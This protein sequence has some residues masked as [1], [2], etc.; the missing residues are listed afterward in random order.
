[1]WTVTTANSDRGLSV[2]LTGK[3]LP[4][5]F[6]DA[7]AEFLVVRVLS[8][9]QL[10]VHVMSYANLAANVENVDEGALFGIHKLLARTR[11]VPAGEKKPVVG[12][13]SQRRV[14]VQ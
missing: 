13:P 2:P 4:S 14:Y 6:S 1:M 8:T 7:I 3:P 10:H 5:C 11:D 12:T 9:A